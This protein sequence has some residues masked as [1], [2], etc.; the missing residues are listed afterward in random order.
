MQ[1]DVWLSAASPLWTKHWFNSSASP[2][3]CLTFRD[4]PNIFRG[5]QRDQRRQLCVWVWFIH[6]FIFVCGCRDELC[7]QTAVFE[8]FLSSC[9]DVHDRIESVFNA[10]PSEAWRSRPVSTGLGLVPRTQRFHLTLWLMTSW[11]AD[12]ETPRLFAVSLWETFFLN[13]CFVCQQRGE[14][15]LI[16]TLW[17]S[18]YTQSCDSPVAS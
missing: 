1:K 17:S 5:S 14:A 8:V 3:S 11:T 9:S 4:A 16:F 12:N 15:L 6:G 2:L 18:F 10:E 13:S 7:S